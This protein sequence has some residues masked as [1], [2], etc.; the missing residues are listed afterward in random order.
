MNVCSL[1]WNVSE[2][3]FCSTNCVVSSHKVIVL[4]KVKYLRKPRTAI[5]Y[6]FFYALLSRDNDLLSRYLDI[7]KIVFS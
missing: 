7:T 1:F 4:F 2:I 6:L 3:T 5:D